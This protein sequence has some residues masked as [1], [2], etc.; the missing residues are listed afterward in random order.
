MPFPL[1]PQE[2]SKTAWTG[3]NFLA[4]F[5][6]ERWGKKISEGRFHS[7]GGVGWKGKMWIRGER[8][9]SEA[10]PCTVFPSLKGKKQPNP[11]T[12]RRQATGF[13]GLVVGADS[14]HHHPT[15]G[16]N[17]VWGGSNHL[18]LKVAEGPMPSTS[19]FFPDILGYPTPSSLIAALAPSLPCGL[20]SPC[21]L[22]G[23]QALDNC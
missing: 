13:H 16:L 5:F 11:V 2:F 14:R 12:P 10:A 19:W 9:S 21:G 6:P 8:E 17:S 4:P 20:Y 1:F 7:R 22:W 23:D 3:S 18:L 15:P